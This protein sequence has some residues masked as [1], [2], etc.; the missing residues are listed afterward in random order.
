MLRHEYADHV[1]ALCATAMAD[2][3]EQQGASVG[4]VNGAA[5]FLSDFA[6]AVARQR[7]P[8]AAD[9]A[10]DA[11]RV[12]AIAMALSDSEPSTAAELLALATR[13]GAT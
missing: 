4:E 12:R 6:D 13:L 1:A 3:L 7:Y 11:N 5:A 2:R 8:E 9:A 10:S